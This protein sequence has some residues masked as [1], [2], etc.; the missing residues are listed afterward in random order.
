MAFHVSDFF[1]FGRTEDVLSIWDIPYIDDL[2]YREDQQGLE[3]Y[4]GMP[5]Y[6][7]DCTQLLWLSALHKY[8]SSLNILHQHDSRALVM[9][10]SNTIYANN[11]IV[12]SCEELGL[13]LCSKFKGKAR[14]S[15]K[16]GKVSFMS[17]LEWQ[18]LYRKHIDPSHKIKNNLGGFLTLQFW[19]LLLVYPR[20]L[21]MEVKLLARRFKYR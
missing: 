6:R 13:G 14:A 2:Q 1:Y 10:A 3:Q 7:K 12:A 18:R 15:R 16:S 21:E 5:F 11:L 20:G 8:D 17:H 9:Q 19:R 4:E